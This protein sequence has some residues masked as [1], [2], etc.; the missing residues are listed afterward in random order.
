MSRPVAAAR[1]YAEAAFEVALA[2]DQLDRWQDDLALAVEMLGRP[3]VEP[4]VDSP[5][6]PLD[7][8]GHRG[9]AAGGA[10]RAAGP[11]AS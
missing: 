4:I 1:R 8:R 5:A 3:D 7:Q 6:I 10:D 2:H 9:R 11:C